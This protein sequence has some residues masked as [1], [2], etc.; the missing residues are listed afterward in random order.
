LTADIL[1]KHF[2]FIALVQ[3]A[4]SYFIMKYANTYEAKKT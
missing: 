3:Y 2:E 1:S 4:S